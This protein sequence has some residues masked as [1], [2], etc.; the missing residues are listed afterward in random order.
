MKTAPVQ[1]KPNNMINRRYK[2]LKM[3]R[4]TFIAVAGANLAYAASY[5]IDHRAF[6]TILTGGAGLFSLRCVETAINKLLEI[7]P[8]Y[9]EF[10][11]R[12]KNINKIKSLNKT[13]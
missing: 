1:I 8:Q 13:V 10:K 12:A 11:E 2:A 4:N 3:T 9:Q 6:M 5:A 7:K